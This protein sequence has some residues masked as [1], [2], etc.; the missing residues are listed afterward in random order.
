MREMITQ[1]EVEAIKREMMIDMTFDILILILIVVFGRHAS[2]GIP[3]FTWNIIYFVILGL[4][5]I[6]NFLRIVVVRISVAFAPWYTLISFLIF[7]GFFLGWLIYGNILFYSH[8][9]DC[10]KVQ[11]SAILYN[12]MLALLIIGY[13]QMLLYGCI[14]LCLPCL[15]FM[16]MHSSQRDRRVLSGSA[17]PQVL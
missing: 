6:S 5:T 7:D 14:I 2:C 17:I 4:R 15:F 9:N 16:I 12:L 13:F 1:E 10:N 3:I 11:N 8:D